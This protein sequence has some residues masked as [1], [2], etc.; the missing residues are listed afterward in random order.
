MRGKIFISYRREDSRGAAGRI[1]DRLEHHF[2]Q[3]H[4]FM[5]VDAIEP[6]EDFVQAI[7][8]AVSSTDIFLVV[9]G[10]NWLNATDNSGNR[11]LDNPEDFVRVEVVSALKR[12]VRVIPVLVDKATMPRSIDLPE[13]LKLLSRRNAIEISHTRF[14]MDAERLIRSIELA[15]NQIEIERRSV[16]KPAVEK[17]RDIPRNKK[18]LV[19][20]SPVDAEIEPLNQ[21]SKNTLWSTIIPCAIGV[22]IGNI[23]GSV[24]YIFLPDSYDIINLIGSFPIFFLMVAL[25]G[26]FSGAV[27]GLLLG[28]IFRKKLRTNWWIQ[29]LIASIYTFIVVI[30]QIEI[31]GGEYLF[32]VLDVIVL[33]LINSVIY[34]I[35]I[36]RHNA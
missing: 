17:N 12:D 28:I 11:R 18:H 3:D 10:P 33:V 32:P 20:S 1:Y 6:G 5:D 29:S 27:V 2:G 7:E 34:W 14:S 24:P 13:D 31:K 25:T 15:F 35:S 36:N 22:A 9:I 8:N 23:V 30:F 16:E 4:I 19:Q 26:L 21:P